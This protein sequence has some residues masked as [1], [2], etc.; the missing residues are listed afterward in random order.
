MGDLP[1]IFWVVP[2][3]GVIALAFAGYLIWNVMRRDPGTKEM[4]DIGN[5]ILEGAKAFL[6]RQYTTIAILSIVVAVVIA[7]LVG[8]L[9]G[10]AEIAKLGVGKFAIEIGRA[11]V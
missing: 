9:Q 10:D 8:F 6:K 2:I 11:H 1:G 5:I 4:Q 3:A 7:L